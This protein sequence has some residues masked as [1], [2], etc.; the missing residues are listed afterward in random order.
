MIVDFKPSIP[1]IAEIVISFFLLNLTLSKLLIILVG[2]FLNFLLIS[3]NISL[4]LIKKYFGLYFL[5]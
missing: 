1:G 2:K 4:L 5:I 3:L